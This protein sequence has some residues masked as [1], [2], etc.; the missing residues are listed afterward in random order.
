LLKKLLSVVLSLFLTMPVAVAEQRVIA[1]PGPVA[2]SSAPADGQTAP[3][4]RP[5]AFSEEEAAALE[6]RAEEPGPEV[7]GG[8]LS[9]LHLTYAVI[10][11]AA[12]VLVLI[13]K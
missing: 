5:Q 8:A 6:A 3:A 7:A 9:N 12:I 4:P 2:A 13:A 11:L 10:A 1:Q